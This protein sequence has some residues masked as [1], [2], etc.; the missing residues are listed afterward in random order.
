MCARTKDDSSDFSDT[1]PQNE[2]PSNYQLLVHEDGTPTAASQ[3][4]I[5]LPNSTSPLTFENHHPIDVNSKRD[6]CP[7]PSMAGRS[8]ANFVTP[9]HVNRAAPAI[10]PVFRSLSIDS[11]LDNLSTTD[12]HSTVVFPPGDSTRRGRSLYQR[13]QPPP[14]AVPSKRLN[15]ITNK[16]TLSPEMRG[17]F[18]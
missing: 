15:F 13:T 11:N 8:I 3:Y 9:T 4:V 6:V 10:K 7:F 5:H 18:V 12:F 2:S 1:M 16:N 14:L 17:S